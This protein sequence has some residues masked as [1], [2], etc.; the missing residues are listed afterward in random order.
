MCLGG[1][2]Q[3]S[4]NQNFRKLNEHMEHNWSGGGRSPRAR[5]PQVLQGATELMHIT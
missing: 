3:C 1:V 4:Q 2:A 5:G